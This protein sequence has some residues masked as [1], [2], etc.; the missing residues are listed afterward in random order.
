MR[1]LA[2]LMERMP[3]CDAWGHHG[4]S[5]SPAQTLSEYGLRPSGT[6]KLRGPIERAFGIAWKENSRPRNVF[7]R[8]GATL[9]TADAELPSLS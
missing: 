4:R 9:A 2:F 6:S 8:G 7:R 3:Y 1:P 5:N